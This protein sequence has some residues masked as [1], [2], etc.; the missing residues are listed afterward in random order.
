MVNLHLI[1]FLICLVPASTNASTA[2]LPS[3][4][5]III[6]LSDDQ[7][8]GDVGYASDL[9]IQP[10]AGGEWKANPPRT[11]NLD[12]MANGENSLLFERFYAGSAVCSPTRAAILTG[13]TPNRECIYSAEGCGQQPAWSCND[14]LPLPPTTWTM[15]EAAKSVG[16]RTIHVGKW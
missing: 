11:P 13:R 12:A 2:N 4:P 6:L 16:Y 15:A 8:W 10:G 5:N 1:F 9:A 14:P 7:G 3:R